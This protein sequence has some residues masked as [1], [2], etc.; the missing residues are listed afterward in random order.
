[1]SDAG[2]YPSERNKSGFKIAAFV[3]VAAVPPVILL[4]LVVSLWWAVAG[5]KANRK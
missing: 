3:L 2:P 5:F 1:M 4:G